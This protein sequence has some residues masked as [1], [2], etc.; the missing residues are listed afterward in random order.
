MTNEQ[1]LL[2]QIFEWIDRTPENLVRSELA[3]LGLGGTTTRELLN[4][5]YNR[6][7]QGMTKLAFVAILE[8]DRAS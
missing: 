1:N 7:P 2:R 6:R 4:R 5:T 3:R 8:G